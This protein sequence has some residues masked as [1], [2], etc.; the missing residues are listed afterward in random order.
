[1]NSMPRIVKESERKIEIYKITNLFN[2]KLYIGQAVSHILNHKKYRLYG[3]EGRF[4]CHISESKSNKTNQCHY[5]NNSIRKHGKDN[6]KV[7]LLEVCNM[8]KGDELETKYI[9]EY[10]SLFPSGYNLK[11]GGKVF[12]HTDESKKRVSNGVIK[13]FE[14]KK[15]LRFYNIVLPEDIINIEKYIRPLNRHNTQYGWYVYISNIKADF[16]GSHISLD[17]SKKMAQEFIKKLI[18]YNQDNIAKHLAAGNPLES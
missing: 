18:K 1:M 3:F 9:L 15:M 11:T 13:Y 6:F 14:D 16:G 8:N 4:K 12:K 17:N 2:N 7:E 10:N 5:L